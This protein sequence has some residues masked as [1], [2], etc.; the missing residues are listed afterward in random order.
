MS[1]SHVA[2]SKVDV[3]LHVDNHHWVIEK[4]TTSTHSRTYLS[5]VDWTYES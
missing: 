1:R 3:G 5:E 2:I 4:E